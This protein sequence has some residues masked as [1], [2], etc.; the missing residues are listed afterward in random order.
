MR[1]STNAKLLYATLAAIIIIFVAAYLLL[2]KKPGELVCIRQYF[3]GFQQGVY[4]VDIKSGNFVYFEKKY[5]TRQLVTATKKLRPDETAAIEKLIYKAKLY[6]FYPKD[7]WFKKP[8]VERMTDGGAILYIK[9][10]NTEA[11]FRYCP[12]E[13]L[14]QLNEDARRRYIVIDQIGDIIDG[15]GDKVRNSSDVTQADTNEFSQIH[16]DVMRAE[17]NIRPKTPFR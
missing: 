16:N 14:S 13:Y 6:S 12:E 10:E 2:S 4:E 5:K 15:I 9:W 7:T 17:E 11:A 3:Y 8:E 1:V